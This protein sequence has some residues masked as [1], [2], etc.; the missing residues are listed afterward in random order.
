MIKKRLIPKLYLRTD[1][2][3][4]EGRMPLFMRF[5]RIDG[6]EPKFS[7]GGIRLS[8]D[9]WDRT[10]NLP[11]DEK[12]RMEIENELNRIKLEIHRCNINNVPIDIPKLREIVKEIKPIDPTKNL[13]IN[14]YQ[15]FLSRKIN[16]GL[17]RQSTIR[18][19][20]SVIN[21]LQEFNPKLRVCDINERVVKQ[22]ISF[23]KRRKK[24]SKKNVS[25]LIF[26]K[27]QIQ[28]R[29]VIRYIAAKGITIQDPFK[30]HEIVIPP[31]KRNEIYLNEVELS[32]MI[33][34]I[35]RKDLS[36]SQHRI[37]LMFLLACATGIRI[38]DIRQLHWENIKLDSKYGTIEFV[39]IKTQRKVIVPLSPMASDILCYATEDD[40]S[41][42][43]TKYSLFVKIYSATKINSTLKNLAQ[44]AGITKNIT[45]HAARRTF[46][47]LCRDY[48]VP[49]D[50]IQSILGH[51]PSTVT[52][53]YFQ[54][55]TYTANKAAEHLLRFNMNYFLKLA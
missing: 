22:F 35:F 53:R 9:E 40:I 20:I 46:A 50:I 3:D 5:P 29:S 21:A 19:H 41:N 10:D 8:F 38:S 47:T 54:W 2:I 18:S 45:F 15:E 23:L 14:Y 44:K 17:I 36:L 51:K 32:K 30:N 28:I 34:L 7:T 42:V 24:E 33:R 43:E 48:G 49:F 55:D 27:R 16:N 11:K 37:L 4:T 31:Y 1:K 12:L 13:F 52:E 6:T 39:C 26:G 25:N